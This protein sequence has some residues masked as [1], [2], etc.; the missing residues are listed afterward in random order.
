[1][2]DKH[3]IS[4]FRVQA[5][6]CEKLG[7]PL[8]AALL[9][10]AMDDFMANGPV[11]HLLRGWAGDPLDENLPLRLAGFFHDQALAGLAPEL[12]RFYETCGGGFAP[13]DADVLWQAAKSCLAAQDA[14]AR[15]FLRNAPQTNEAGRAAILLAGFSEIAR[16]TGLPLRLREIGA[17]AG[18]NLFFDHF[19]YKIEIDKAALNWGDAN[20]PLTIAAQWRGQA[21][22]MAQAIEVSDRRGCDLFPIDLGDATARRRMASYIWGDMAQR[23]DRQQQALAALKGQVPV[24]DRADAAGWVAA[25]IMQRP[26]GQAT[27]LYHSIVWPYL[28][29]SQRFAIE[30]A[31]AQAAEAV[32]PDAPLVW[33]KMD[34]RELGTIAQ[35]SYRLWSG[36]NGPEGEEVIL[37]PCH[38]HGRDMDIT[39][40]F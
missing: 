39:A 10:G 18:L 15:R 34:G 33:L 24:I 32:R 25:Q 40:S 29:V 27:V 2:A 4:A 37:G 5:E 38:P 16:H 14:A 31:F 7:S 8:T 13:S 21:P 36:E 23:A 19:R 6:A 3:I 26:Q 30:S 12:A 35:L 20:S 1:M 11:A 9:R 28:S 22:Q 17:S